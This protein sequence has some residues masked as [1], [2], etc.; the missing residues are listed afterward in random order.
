MRTS[1]LSTYIIDRPTKNWSDK[2]KLTYTGGY[3]Q[4]GKPRK[5]KIKKKIKKINIISPPTYRFRFSSNY[6]HTNQKCLSS[7]LEWNIYAK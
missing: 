4:R 1:N 2:C 7:V 6:L 5:K 3:R